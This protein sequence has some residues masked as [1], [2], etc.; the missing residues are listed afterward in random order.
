MSEELFCLSS[1][2][3]DYMHCLYYA[4]SITRKSFFVALLR[5]SLAVLGFDTHESLSKICLFLLYR[6]ETKNLCI[7]KCP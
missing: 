2:F 3:V 7:N 6:V 5:P 1:S 4:I